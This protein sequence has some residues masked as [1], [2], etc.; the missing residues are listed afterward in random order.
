MT[1]DYPNLQRQPFLTPIWLT[2]LA[3][4]LAVSFLGFAA[5]VL[6][7]ADS[8]TIVVVRH[9]EK[10]LNAD[11]PA[12]TPAGEAHAALLARLFGD[13]RGTEHIDAIYVS[14]ALLDRKM[15]APLAARLG[16]A[17]IVAASSDARAVAHR[18]LREHAGGRVLV[19]GQGDWA[20]EIVAALSG[21]KGL[22]PIAAEEYGRM[23]I[24]S[25][26]RIGRANLLVMEY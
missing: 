9:A 16:L 12:L 4:L 23:Y 1:R 14:S 25:V 20:A 2:V 18:V 26:P 6:G 15:A 5:W 10:E 21:V 17:P 13:A 19:I 3:A 7:T 24:V 11:D 22:A 8:T